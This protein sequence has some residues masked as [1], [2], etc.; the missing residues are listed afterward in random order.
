MSASLFLPDKPPLF[1]S[2]EHRMWG[3]DRFTLQSVLQNLHYFNSLSNLSSLSLSLRWMADI[4]EWPAHLCFSSTDRQLLPGDGGGGNKQRKNNNREITGPRG[5]NETETEEE[6][7]A[8]IELN[9]VPGSFSGCTRRASD[10]GLIE[11]AGNTSCVCRKGHPFCRRTLA[12][13][14]TM[15]FSQERALIKR[16]VVL[17]SSFPFIF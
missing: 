1:L 9:R 6:E 4:L 10:V 8:V 17:N 16:Q 2:D 7:K 15:L 14:R 5:G 11:E 12:Q 13:Q 3:C